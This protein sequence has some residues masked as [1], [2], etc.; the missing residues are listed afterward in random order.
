[1]PIRPRPPAFAAALVAL[2]CSTPAPA[3]E[4]T[5]ME[6]VWIEAAAPDGEEGHTFPAL[7]NLPP[8]WM[9]GDA[10]ALVLFDAPWPG[11]A[12]ENLVAAL[13]DEGAAVL[14]LDANAAREF[15][16]ENPRAGPEPTAAELALDVRAAVGGLRRDTG[17][18]LVVALGHG[19]GGNAAV[20]AASAD[21]MA[22]RPDDAGLAAAASLGP[23]LAHFALGGAAPG[24]GW[25]VRAERLCRVLAA[26]VAAPSGAR[27]EAE[28]RRALADPGGTY[29]AAAKAR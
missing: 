14:E 1:M 25:P 4:H 11:L 29:A 26:V 27:T 7:L 22:A 12:R 17:A 5:R 16:P 28:C 3:Q 6:P 2:A 24:R 23:G 10:A 20:L 19:A 13:L 9:V 18:G 21:R 15:G 8:G